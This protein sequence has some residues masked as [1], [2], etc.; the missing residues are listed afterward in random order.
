MKVRLVDGSFF[1]RERSATLAGER[2]GEGPA[3]FEWALAG[4]PVTFY[5]DICLHQAEGAPGR[6]VAWLLEPQWKPD[7]Y[8]TAR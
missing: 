8:E 2:S 1:S 6:K 4:G 3:S 7:A 5:T